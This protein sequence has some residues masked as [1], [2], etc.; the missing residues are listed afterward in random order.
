MLP[1]HTNV[2]FDIYVLASRLE[3]DE[4]LPEHRYFDVEVKCNVQVQLKDVRA[5]V[6]LPAHRYVDI[7][8]QVQDCERM[9]DGQEVRRRGR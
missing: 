2:E 7:N 4:V 1:A 6:V 8:M 5:Y 9:Y 3:C